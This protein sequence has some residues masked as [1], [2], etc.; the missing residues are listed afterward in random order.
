MKQKREEVHIDFTTG[1]LPS[2]RI[3]KDGKVVKRANPDCFFDPSPV[4][5]SPKTNKITG[6]E[7]K[8]SQELKQIEKD[9]M[10]QQAKDERD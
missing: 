4:V 7:L 1:V 8:K 5:V 3:G 6:H 10:I 9:R 2:D